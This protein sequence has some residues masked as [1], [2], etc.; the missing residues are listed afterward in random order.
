MWDAAAAA[1]FPVFLVALSMLNT[2]VTDT[3]A[4]PCVRNTAQ[5]RKV[6]TYIKDQDIKE[7]F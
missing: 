4:I 7:V 5:F 2:S 3:T 1:F 6:R